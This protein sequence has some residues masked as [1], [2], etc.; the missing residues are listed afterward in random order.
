MEGLA[1]ACSRSPEGAM[2]V[3]RLM[4]PETCDQR[5]I[6]AS[7][8]SNLM[9]GFKKLLAKGCSLVVKTHDEDIRPDW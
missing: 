6:A 7:A 8:I 4:Q 9:Q 3:D 2:A 5:G 1:Q